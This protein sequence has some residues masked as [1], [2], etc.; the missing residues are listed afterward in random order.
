MISVERLDQDWFR[1]CCSEHAAD[2]LAR[3]TEPA[4]AKAKD[5]G[6]SAPCEW[7]TSSRP[8]ASSASKSSSCGRCMLVT[9]SSKAEASTAQSIALKTRTLSPP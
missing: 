8:H 5:P 3:I 1:D 9:L 2:T 6:R 4:A 7:D